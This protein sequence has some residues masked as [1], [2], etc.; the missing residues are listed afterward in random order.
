MIRVTPIQPAQRA[1]LRAAAARAVTEGLD[2][3]AR[4][5]QSQ[6]AMVVS[7]WTHH[8]VFAITAPSATV[9][10]VATD[11]AIFRYQDAGTPPHEI[12]PRARRMLRFSVGGTEVFARRVRHPGTRAQ[13]YTTTIADRM[14]VRLANHIRVAVLRQL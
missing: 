11:D 12:R 5:A 14:T 2:A 8:V 10:E 6:L 13:H 7:P 3:A 4:D 9:R 1:R